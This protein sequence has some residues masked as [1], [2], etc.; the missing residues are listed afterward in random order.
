MK[1]ADLQ[2]KF[3]K[4]RKPHLTY[5]F[6]KRKKKKRTKRIT[7]IMNLATLFLIRSLVIG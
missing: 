5:L 6:I 4:L 7:Q 1:F 3:L 2:S